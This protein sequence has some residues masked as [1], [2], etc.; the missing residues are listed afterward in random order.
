MTQRDKDE[1]NKHFLLLAAIMMLIIFV[2]TIYVIP[3]QTYKYKVD[4]KYNNSTYYTNDVVKD[5]AT[6]VVTV[7][8]AN[9][10]SITIQDGVVTIN[11]EIK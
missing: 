1:I 7:K 3:K 11:P 10:K 2:G 5:T 9:G 4:D 8:I 6:N